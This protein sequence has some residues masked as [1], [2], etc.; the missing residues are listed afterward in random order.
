MLEGLDGFVPA[1]KEGLSLLDH[2]AYSTAMAALAFTDAERL[3]DALDVAAALDL[4][5][6]AANLTVLDPAVA[7]VRPFAG[8]RR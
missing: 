4:E 5:A 1:A 8:W 2:N 7:R 6:L 3:L